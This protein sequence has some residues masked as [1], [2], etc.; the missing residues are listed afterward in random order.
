ML[1]T[2]ETRSAHAFTIT[3]GQTLSIVDPLGGQVADLV[4]FSS[5]DT[6]EYLA[7][8]RTLDYESTLFLT[9]G[10]RLWSNRS[11]PLLEIIAD[12]VGR[13]DFLLAPC[14][15]EMF[16]ILYRDPHPHR[17]CFGNLVEVL[18][19][20]GIS[21]D[22]VP[23][24]FNI[25]MNVVINGQTGQLNVAPPLS[26]AG[27]KITFHALEDLVIGLTACSAP[28]SNGGTFKPIQYEIVG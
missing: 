8:G 12:D 14:S 3:K 22:S 9:T 5:A 20:Y 15:A 24:A 11:R 21:A 26:R 27:D 4:A 23:V 6:A 2:I 28:L 1:K 16:S 17:G 10:H 18:E 13:H 7:S 19:P 25:F